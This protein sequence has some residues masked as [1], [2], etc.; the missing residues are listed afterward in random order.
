M[1]VALLLTCCLSPAARPR[2]RQT[3]M[4]PTA[5]PL[6][7]SL[8]AEITFNAVISFRRPVSSKADPKISTFPVSAAP[9]E[10]ERV[11]AGKQAAKGLRNP[12]P[13]HDSRAGQ[14]QTNRSRPPQEWQRRARMG[15]RIKTVP[16]RLAGAR[17]GEVLQHYP[18]WPFP[19]D[20][21]LPTVPSWIVAIAF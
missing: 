1:R 8:A 2:G 21:V 16:S 3:L 13:V 7:R 6:G 5:K 19:L 15:W 17:F 4:T 20:G 14:Y 10:N 11:K 9:R 12:S 18:R